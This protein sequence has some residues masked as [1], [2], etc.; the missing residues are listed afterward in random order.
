MTEDVRRDA[1]LRGAVQEAVDLLAPGG[2]RHRAVQHG[3]AVGSQPVDLAGQ[4]EHGSAAE[5]DDD[6]PRR[7]P[8]QLACA[9]ELE[10][11]LPLV[12]S[13]LRVR[14]GVTDE[15]ERVERAEQAEVPVLAGEQE[16][17]PGSPPLLVVGPLHLVHDEDV[18][19]SGRHLDRAAE[20]R[21]VLVDA[22]FPRDETDF[23]RA[24]LR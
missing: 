17:R 2:E 6:R 7:E 19:G 12:D 8:S 9:D 21:R 5:G 10:R 4:R 14:E 11:E 15:R 20:D 24:E 22:L 13:E 16:L 23:A 3:D 1:H 18:A